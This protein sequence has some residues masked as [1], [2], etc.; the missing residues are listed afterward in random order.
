MDIN[1]LRSILTVLVVVAFSGIVWWV[2]SSRHKA[3]YE[4]AALI[5]LDDDAPFVSSDASRAGHPDK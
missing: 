1:D 4:R 2:Y 3:G 5:P